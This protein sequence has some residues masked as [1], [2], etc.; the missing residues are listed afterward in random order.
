MR[1]R[2]QQLEPRAQKFARAELV[3]VDTSGRSP[4]DLAGIQERA[5]AA[6]ASEVIEVHMCVAAAMREAE[7]MMTLDRHQVL[8][9]SRLIITSSTRP[10]SAVACLLHM[11][12]AGS[13]LALHERARVPEDIQLASAEALAEVLCGE[14][15]Q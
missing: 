15:I 12:T 2:R 4:R 14:E 6:R 8:S 13:A 3:L 1:D 5:T 7:L 9:A 11:S 10:R